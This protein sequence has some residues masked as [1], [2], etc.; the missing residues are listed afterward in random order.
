[1]NESKK[2]RN[3]LFVISDQSSRSSTYG[4]VQ[5]YIHINEVHAV[6]FSNTRDLIV[7]RDKINVFD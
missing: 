4:S 7:K 5:M 2:G 3:Y 6:R 1:M